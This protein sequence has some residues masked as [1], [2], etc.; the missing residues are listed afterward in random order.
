MK[1]S[2]LIE[3]AMKE[4]ED[5]YARNNIAVTLR[6]LFYILVSKNVLPNT[7]SAYKRLSEI[8]AK[9]R[10]EKKFP[11]HLIR[12]VTRSSAYLEKTEYYPSELSEEDLR[13]LIESTLESYSTYSLNPWKDQPKRVI[14][15]VEKEAQYELVKKV[16]AEN[17]KFGVYKIVFSRGYD[18]ATDMI[19]LAEEIKSLNE[20][21]YRAVLL[22]ITDFD[23]SGEDIARDYVERLKYIEPSLDFEAEKVAVTREQIEKFNLP[24]TPESQEELEKL[25]RDPRFKGFVDK[26]GLV[27]V[28]LD[29]LVALRLDDFKQILIGAIK[30]HFDFEVYEKVTKKR[31]EE[32]KAKADEARKKNIELL[33][34]VMS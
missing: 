16:V 21:G 23:P 22:I 13:R 15:L 18:S 5:Y 19:K 27:R 8:I 30:K 4:A 2:S 3:I 20:D 32:L 6:G 24:C 28:E 26:W 7:K 11:A 9:A 31:E 33:K 29:A 17:F 10:Y 14:V 34:K 1:S 25:R 12:D